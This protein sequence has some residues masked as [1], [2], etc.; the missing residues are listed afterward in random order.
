[1]KKNGDTMR[2]I[3]LRVFHVTSIAAFFSSSPGAILLL[4]VRVYNPW[5]S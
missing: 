2:L 3:S 1:M 5:I 4:G